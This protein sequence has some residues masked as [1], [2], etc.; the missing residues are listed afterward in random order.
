[1]DDLYRLNLFSPYFEMI[2]E[3]LFDDSIKY[4]VCDIGKE[5]ASTKIVSLSTS[6]IEMGPSYAE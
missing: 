4:G 2:S 5:K 6:V 1:M 3:G